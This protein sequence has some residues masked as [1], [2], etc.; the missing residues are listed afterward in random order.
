MTIDPEKFEPQGKPTVEQVRTVWDSMTAPSVRKV[1]ELLERRGFTISFRT[2]ARWKKNNWMADPQSGGGVKTIS[3]NQHVPGAIRQGIRSELDKIDPATVHEA[4]QTAAAG[5]LVE[6]IAGGGLKDD[7]IT[8]IAKRITELSSE[9]RA[10]LLEKQ[11]TARIVM[12][13][14]LM[15]EATRRAHVMTLIPKDTSAFVESFTDASKAL[16]PMA[17]IEPVEPARNGDNARLIEGTATEL[18]PLSQ[19]IRSVREK[20]LA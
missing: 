16:P 13:I 20:A 1:A 6:V 15:E 2:V 19:A 10:S 17:P 3:E 11:E 5:G 9:T 14:V 4:N 8:R 18:S 12:N 7:D